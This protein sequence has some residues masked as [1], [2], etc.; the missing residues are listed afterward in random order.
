MVDSL[1]TRFI[2]RPTET[3]QQIA[4]PQYSVIVQ[5]PQ[6]PNGPRPMVVS[7]DGEVIVDEN[8]RIIS[9]LGVYP[10]EGVN[11]L[12]GY[13]QTAGIQEAIATF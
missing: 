4:Q 1:T 13:T 10:T 9:D 7:A 6:G 3:S 8:G 2:M 11:E 12:G 5:T